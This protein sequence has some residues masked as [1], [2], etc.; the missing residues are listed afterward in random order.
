M[1]A[2]SLFFV[3]IIAVWFIV[4]GQH[5]V[6]RREDL[7]TA[8]SVDRFS[9]AMRVLER[10]P[11]VRH[12]RAVTQ[13]DSGAGI[14]YPQ[15]SASAETSET[16][17]SETL[18]QPAAPRRGSFRIS[19]PA[20]KVPN[21]AAPTRTVKA[22]ALMA[23]AAFTLLTA[24][25]AVFSVVSWLLPL[26]GLLA[27]G[28]VI[29][30]LRR[31]AAAVRAQ[32]ASPKRT[33]VSETTSAAVASQPTKSDAPFDIASPL[34]KKAEPAVDV[35][36]VEQVVKTKR[37]R[38]AAE[39]EVFDAGW[40][41]VAVP[42][43]TYTMKA[44]AEREPVLPAPTVDELSPRPLAAQYANT[45]VEELPFDGM[46]LDEDYDDLPPVYLAS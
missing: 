10:R 45:P 6:R 17:T 23:S 1:R 46:A 24:V 43:P 38:S 41:P 15:S 14:L 30:L 18:A 34:L 13:H 22:G 9:D 39:D 42:R 33:L 26:V 8:R 44:K 31:S 12:E 35:E 11:T 19:M 25:L 32:A 7:T 29:A 37:T 20:V 36:P 4:M 16:E 5:W 40:E 3:V 28:T 2:S 27:T 21:F